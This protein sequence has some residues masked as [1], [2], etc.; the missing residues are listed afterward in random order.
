MLFRQLETFAAVVRYHSFAKAAE[1]CY[2]TQ[3]AVSQQVKQLEQF[4]GIELLQRQGRRFELTQSGELVARR[5]EAILSQVQELRSEIELIKNGVQKL[6]LGYLNRYEGWELES[7]MAAMNR[8]HPE[9]ELSAIAMTHEELYEKVREHSLDIIVS[10]QRRALSDQFVNRPLFVGYDFVELSEGSPLA[11]KTELTVRDLDGLTC[12]LLCPKERESEE[13]AYY[14]G[15]LNFRCRFIVTATL[16]EARMLV[17]GNRG[18]LPVEE[19]SAQARTSGVIRRIPLVEKG[20]FLRHRYFAFW[21]KR[22]RS[23]LTEEFASILSDLFKE[24]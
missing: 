12:I 17:A 4:L 7:A 6:R 20:E 1:A 24:G 19:R 15:T 2:V 9:L 14:T 22:Y 11:H 8:R 16:Q 13:I 3:S 23:A 5:A 18:F 21:P 10:D